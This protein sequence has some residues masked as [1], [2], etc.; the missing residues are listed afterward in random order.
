MWQWLIRPF[1]SFGERVAVFSAWL[2]AMLAWSTGMSMLFGPQ[3]VREAGEVYDPTAAGWVIIPMVTALVTFEEIVRLLPLA[4]TVRFSRRSPG[5][6][7][8]AAVITAALFG[9]AHVTNGLPLW[10]TIICQG[11]T[12]FVMNLLY[13]KGGGLHG[14]WFRGFLTAL[15]FHVAFDYAILIPALL[16][17]GAG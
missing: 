9:A 16:V 6:V 8:S 7:M 11:A 5:A 12:G 14:R 4:L 10:F 3:I 1:A 13:L 17:Q 2:L 15:A